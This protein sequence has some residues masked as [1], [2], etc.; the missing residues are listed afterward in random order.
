MPL[1]N[2]KLH[3]VDS[4]D[5]ASELMQWLGTQDAADS[6]AVDTETTGLVHGKDYVRM[7]QVGGFVNGWS[8]P[9]H[10]WSG[11]F[12]EIIK[13]YE[14]NFDLYHAKFDYGMLKLDPTSPI[15]IP[16]YRIHD[17]MLSA[18]INEPHMS[19]ALKSQASRHIDSAAGGL[20][21]K[22]DNT[23]W[24]WK[25]IPWD[26]E[27]YWTYAALDTVLTK[28]VFEYHYPT[29]MRE[30]PEAYELERAYQW[31]AY[32]MERYGAHID[33]EYAKKKYDAFIKYVDD[34]EKWIWD[35]YNVKAG[36]N[37][38][39][40]KV[41]EAAGFSFTKATK[42][43][44][45]ALDQDVLGEIDHPLAQTVLKRRKLQK[46]ATTYLRHFIDEVD[47]NDCI[48]PS[49]NT[50][51]ARTSRMSMSEPNLQNLPRKSELNPAATTIR[52]SITTRYGDKGRLLMC[53]FDQIEMRLMAHM[54]KDPGLIAAFMSDN[55]F[56]VQLARQIYQD[57]TITKKDP[58][59]QITKNAGYSEIYG[60]GIAKFAVTAGVDEQQAGIVKGRWNQLY[61]GTKR[62]SDYVQT[63]AWTHQ[64]TEGQPYIR[65][66][67]TNRKQIADV[68]K[69]YPLVNYSIQ[70][71]AAEVFK[72]KQLALAAA[73]LDKFM[74]IPVHDEIILDVPEEDVPEVVEVLKRVMNDTES[75]SVPITA[76][77]S[78]GKRWGEKEDLI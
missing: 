62:Y 24:T 28:H 58:R 33:V 31:V 20:Q 52:N 1:D 71:F 10:L 75:F 34:A 40:I 37:A 44:A 2:V 42:S 45:K 49:L 18:H 64:R 21:M 32:D 15:E 25:T 3:L 70:M 27:P 4:Y 13:R 41:L 16:R 9:W 65:S 47:S 48:H 39:I 63:V 55:D 53:D 19:K 59:R 43:G 22:L 11:L 66:P 73:G 30:A 6:I 36:S 29:V 54:S 46:L 72:Q 57:D 68:N 12:H 56:F 67:I 35:N 77:V 61:P 51:G 50:L 8:I 17:A 60:A 23:V 14:G 7:A 5:K 38:A 74:V 26:Y 76:S 78:H 69:I